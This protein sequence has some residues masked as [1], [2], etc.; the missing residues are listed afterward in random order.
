MSY[1]WLDELEKP[2]QQTTGTEFMRP[3]KCSS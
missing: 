2:L 3:D 1:K